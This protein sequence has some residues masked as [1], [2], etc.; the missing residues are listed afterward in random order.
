MIVDGDAISNASITAEQSE[1]T[2]SLVV[3]KVPLELAS[4]FTS[5]HT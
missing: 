3:S 2:V 1:R 4:E 5:V